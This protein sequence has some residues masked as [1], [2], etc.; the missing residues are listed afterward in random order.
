[1]SIIAHRRTASQNPSTRIARIRA[2]RQRHGLL[3]QPPITVGVAHTFV[4]LQ[5]RVV[6]RAVGERLQINAVSARTVTWRRSRLNLAVQNLR[7][8]TRP[9]RAPE[10]THDLRRGA[11]PRLITDLADWHLVNL[12]TIS[13][14]NRRDNESQPEREK[15]PVHHNTLNI[16]SQTSLINV[17]I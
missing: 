14:G 9:R 4:T 12:P 3:V 11:Q 17:T 7:E 15:L 5:N 6:R 8:R 10:I 1:M 16:I 2:G 13:R